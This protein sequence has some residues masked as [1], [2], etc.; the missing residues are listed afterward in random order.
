MSCR[1]N[2]GEVEAFGDIIGDT[3]NGD[4]WQL[5]LSIEHGAPR[6]SPHP[7]AIFAQSIDA[8]GDSGRLRVISKRR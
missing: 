1:L 4:I 5:R 8:D 2:V 6:Q 3:T 7:D